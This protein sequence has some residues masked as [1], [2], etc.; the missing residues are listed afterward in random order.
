M[1]YIPPTAGERFYLR[2]LL[3]VVRGPT[4]FDDLLYVSGHAQACENFHDACVLQG[5]LEDDGE[6]IMCFK[7][8]SKMCTDASL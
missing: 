4:S 8:A 5:L 7:E 6:W 1:V 3:T 2:T